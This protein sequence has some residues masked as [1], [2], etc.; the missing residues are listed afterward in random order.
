VALG[1]ILGA[2]L[3]LLIQIP[4]ARM[5]G[6]KYR[7]IF[8]FGFP[9]IIKT[10]KL[11]V[12]RSIGTAAYQVNLIVITGIAS[13]LTTGSIAVFSFA[14]NIN[15]IPVSL[16]GISFALASFPVLSQSWASGLREKFSENFSSVF[17][18]ILY[19]ILPVS[20]LMFLLRA[21][22]VRLILGTGEFGWLET[23]LT[24]ASLGLFCLSIFAA[25]FIPLLSR[26]FYSFQDTRTPVAIGISA[27]ILNVVLSFLLVW[28]LSFPNFFREMT[29]NFL[30][31]QGIENIEVVGLAL[32]ISV[33]TVFQFF[34]LLVFLKK[35]MG[36][37]K[38]REIRHSFRKIIIATILMA[39][40]T[41]LALQTAVN[42]V[43]MR[44]FSGVLIQTIFA[45]LIGA[46]I[47]LLLTF[48]LK[49]PEFKTIWSSISEQF[50]HS[51]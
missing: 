25:A 43:D 32:A 33:A 30:N 18:Q 5:A 40:F 3:H 51:P 22:I 50:T 11:M 41:Y 42:F 4:A 8:N 49:S 15:F 20:L 44:T 16:I 24:A 14:Q 37:I 35:R 28:L 9:G 38:L 26:V 36:G 39:I 31:L 12:P 10:F 47:Y 27:M 6:F 46:F 2:F 17:R 19:L 34:L 29:A 7:P 48:F 45:V 21:Q 13:T 23:R 1:V